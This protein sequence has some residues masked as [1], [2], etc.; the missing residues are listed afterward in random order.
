LLVGLN[1]PPCGP[2]EEKTV[3]GFTP[4]APGDAE[5]PK[6]DDVAEM[7]GFA[8]NTTRML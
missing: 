7:L 5:T 4:S 1:G 2:D 8:P 6:L 3:D